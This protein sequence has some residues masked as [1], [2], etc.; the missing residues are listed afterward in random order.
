MKSGNLNFQEPSGPL[1][2]CSGTALPYLITI[3]NKP[4][5]IDM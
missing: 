4:F 5:G 2:A 3:I 1:E